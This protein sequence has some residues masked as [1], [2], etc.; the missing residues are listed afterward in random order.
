[1]TDTAIMIT[2]MVMMVMKAMNTRDMHS[3]Q[4]EQTVHEFS[5]TM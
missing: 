2:V 3:Q 4:N 5:L 1:M